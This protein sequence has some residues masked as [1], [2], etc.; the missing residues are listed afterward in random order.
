MSMTNYQK[1]VRLEREVKELLEGAGYTVVRSAGSK[2]LFD[3][4]AVD[5]ASTRLIQ[6]RK[7]RKLSPTEREAIKLVPVTKVTTK[8]VWTRIPGLIGKFDI[9]VID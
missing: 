8:E 5:R 1:G 4:A 2:G 7:N 9:E 6:V 3:L